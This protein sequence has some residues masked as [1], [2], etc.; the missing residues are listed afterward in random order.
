MPYKKDYNSKTVGTGAS[1]TPANVMGSQGSPA[2]I[3]VSYNVSKPTKSTPFPEGK[4]H[5][6]KEKKDES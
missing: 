1:R 2:N 4:A 5:E 3:P 6:S